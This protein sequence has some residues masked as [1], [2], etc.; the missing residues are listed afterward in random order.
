MTFK[1]S[2]GEGMLLIMMMIDK[3]YSY[4]LVSVYLVPD[5]MLCFILLHLFLT[6]TQWGITVSISQK[7]VDE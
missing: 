6:T 1:P 7:Y 5:G 3:E 2:F 4:H